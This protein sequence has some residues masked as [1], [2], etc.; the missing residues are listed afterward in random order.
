[1]KVNELTKKTLRWCEPFGGWSKLNINHDYFVVNLANGDT[2]LCNRILH[3]ELAYYINKYNDDKYNI[4]LDSRDWPELAMITLP[5]TYGDYKSNKV[6]DA[7]FPLDYDKLRFK[8]VFDIEKDK[9]YQAT[10]LDRKKINTLFKSGDLTLEDDHYYSDF[11]YSPIYKKMF[12]HKKFKSDWDN[13]KFMRPLT[14]IKL[15]HSYIDNLIKE[16]VENTVGIHMRRFNGVKTD[17]I[18][19]NN[20]KD[21]KLK[22]VYNKISKSKTVN[23][24]YE[25]FGDDVYFYIIEKMLNHNPQQNFYISHDLPDV[26]L[27]PYIKRF[28]DRIVDRKFFTLPVVSHLQAQ[29]L[30]IEQLRR[31][32]NVI[33]NIIDLFAL[34][35]CPFLITHGDSTWSEFAQYYN[36]EDGMK[37][38]MPINSEV[39]D[40]IQ[41]YIDTDAFI[42]PKKL[43]KLL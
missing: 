4:L 3:W 14:K 17:D 5:N 24:N 39:G 35:Y 19:L 36:N 16:G 32:G 31:D 37:P 2:G 18:S 6:E 33:N 9:T 8:T 23:D 12:L 7:M 41:E 11:G 43:P 40:I 21:K 13:S 27:E 25:F 1:M 28:G 30:N 42:K 26:F 15:S 29:G 38:I 10:K 20:L 22:E 34:A